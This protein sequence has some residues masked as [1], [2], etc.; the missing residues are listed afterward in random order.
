MPEPS[1]VELIDT[2]KILQSKIE[3]LENKLAEYEIRLADSDED[4]FL[5]EVPN[6]KYAGITLGVQFKNGWGFIKDSFP[7][8]AMVAARMANDYGY[9]V[10]RGDTKE[11]KQMIDLE[12]VQGKGMSIEDILKQ[13]AQ[14][15]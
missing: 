8:A 12:P 7:G 11:Y 1:K 2:I 15:I 6:K 10:T 9:T 4:G 13:S 3:D 5:V 14:P